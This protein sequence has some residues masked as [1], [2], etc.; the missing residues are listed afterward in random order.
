MLYQQ[1]IAAMNNQMMNG[2]AANN[3]MNNN[4]NANTNMGNNFRLSSENLDAVAM[5]KLEHD[6]A[7]RNA[8]ELYDISNQNRDCG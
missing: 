6:T 5:A 3:N 2:A 8:L 4:N 7:N 1:N